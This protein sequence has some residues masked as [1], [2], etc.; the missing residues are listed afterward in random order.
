MPNYVVQASRTVLRDELALV[1]YE[2]TAEELLHFLDCGEYEAD[3]DESEEELEE[4][5]LDFPCVREKVPEGVGYRVFAVEDWN[6]EDEELL[7]QNAQRVTTTPSKD[8]QKK[9]MLAG[10]IMLKRCCSDH[11]K[12]LK[13]TGEVDFGATLMMAQLTYYNLIEHPELTGLCSS[14]GT[15]IEALRELLVATPENRAAALEATD[16][17]VDGID[18]DDFA[19]DEAV[20]EFLEKYRP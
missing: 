20:M 19:K 17:A 2:G 6:E 1:E 9:E 10:V 15:L 8:R 3:A 12:T 13:G 4:Y 5:P 11:R 16:K 7:G 14:L 18:V